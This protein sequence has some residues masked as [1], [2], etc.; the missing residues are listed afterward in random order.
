MQMETRCLVF[1]CLCITLLTDE[2]LTQTDTWSFWEMYPCCFGES[3]T[4]FNQDWELEIAVD[5]DIYQKEKAATVG[6]SGFPCSKQE[7]FQRVYPSCRLYLNSQ[8]FRRQHK[9]F[10][11]GISPA[12][13]LECKY[14]DPLPWT[15]RF[16]NPNETFPSSTGQAL[17]IRWMRG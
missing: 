15:H 2:N 8:D 1:A 17:P 4:S 9:A 3:S 16:I 14:E 10:K 6:T 11:W 7:L 12:P 5:T 13:S